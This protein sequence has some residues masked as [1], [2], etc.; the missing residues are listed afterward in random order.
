MVDHQSILETFCQ[1]VS[2]GLVKYCQSYNLNYKKM[3]SFKLFSIKILL[4]ININLLRRNIFK[5]EGSTHRGP[6][7]PPLYVEWVVC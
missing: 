7:Y 1:K 2:N 4:N 3:F 5:R 6:N